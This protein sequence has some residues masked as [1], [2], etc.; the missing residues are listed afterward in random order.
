MV[1]VIIPCYNLAQLWQPSRIN[2]VQVRLS[3][4]E[5]SHTST[6]LI[7]KAVRNPAGPWLT[8]KRTESL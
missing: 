8:T 1:V 4:T 3:L 5:S 7:L 2:P 6:G